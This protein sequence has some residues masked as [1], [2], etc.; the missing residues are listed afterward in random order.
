MV[1]G[2]YYSFSRTS[3]FF[4]IDNRSA[5]N[6]SL[7]KISSFCNEYARV[8]IYP[9]LVPQTGRDQMSD[10]DKELKNR[11]SRFVEE[12]E[13]HRLALFRY[14]L[15][16]TRNPFDAEDLVSEAMMKTFSSRAFTDDSVESTS[17][18]MI[19]VASRTWIDEQQRSAPH[20]SSIE[21]EETG[22]GDGDLRSVV[23]DAT[24]L[25]YDQLNPEQRAVL[26]LK[27]VFGMTHKE[28]SRRLSISEENSRITLH[29]SKAALS[30]DK[31]RVPKIS[32]RLVEQFVEAFL[33]HDIDRVKSLM[34]DEI[35]AVVFPLGREIASKDEVQW[36][37]VSLSHRPSDLQVVDVLGDLAILV[38]RTDDNGDEALE[39]IWLIEESAGLISR[40]V[41][42]GVSPV[43]V[44]WIADFCG[45][46]ARD[47]RFRFNFE[48]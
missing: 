31:P 41:D 19:R 26:V 8:Q 15:G 47:P 38:F 48:E 13:P 16:L 27:E 45:Q 12:A 36:L 42:Y 35:E 10:K 18:F 25:L 39:E 22:S 1:T 2:L 32:K 40:V 20:I 30:A 46:K 44:G 6:S 43:L 29:R 17:A 28:V 37:P 11:W 3:G 5:A 9:I 23:A 34:H 24:H 21:T 7:R 33:S 4:P 14:C